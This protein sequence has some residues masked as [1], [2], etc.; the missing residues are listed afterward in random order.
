MRIVVTGGSGFLG[1]Y[2]VER[3]GGISANHSEYDFVSAED[4]KRMYDELNPDI[5]IHLAARVGG[6][7]FNMDYPAVLFYENIMMGTQ[8]LHEGYVRG[9]KKFI[10]IG[11]TCSYPKHTPIPFKECDIWN[12]YPEETNAPYGMAKKML[13]VQSQA[14]RKQYGFNSIFLI[15]TNMYGCRDNFD[16]NSSHVI[17]SLIRKFKEHDDVIIWGDGSATR[18]FIYVEDAVDAIVLAL[19]KY[20]GIEPINIGTGKQTSISELVKIITNITSFSGDIHWD[21]SKP[22]GQPVRMLDTSVAKTELGFEAKTQ[23]YEGLEKT[24]AWYEDAYKCLAPKGGTT[25][26]S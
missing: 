20:N 19:E 15:P 25:S 18:D 11:T 4:V 1:K 2:V 24:I 26:V 12:G 22:N 13:L 5:V 6:I 3:I 17:P 8:L 23:I 10:S 14:Y 7:G 16:Y 9:I 21:K